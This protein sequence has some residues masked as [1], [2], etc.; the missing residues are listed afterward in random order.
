[1]ANQASD[2]YDAGGAA[3]SQVFNYTKMTRFINRI[4]LEKLTLKTALRATA[5]LDE[6]R[7]NAKVRNGQR[8]ELPVRRRLSGTTKMVSIYDDTSDF[9]GDSPYATVTPPTGGGIN[10][11]RTTYSE[12]DSVRNMEVQWAFMHDNIRFSRVHL[13]WAASEGKF[14]DYFAENMD[15]IAD[16]LKVFAAQQ[17]N[18]G[19]GRG[20]AAANIGNSAEMYG[21]YNQVT[22]WSGNRAANSGRG[23]DNDPNN[24]HFGILRHQFPNMVGN[25]WRADIVFDPASTGAEIRYLDAAGVV[26][27]GPVTDLDFTGVTY[28]NCHT[29]IDLG[30]G[31]LPTAY[32][33][34]ELYV[35]VMPTT[36]SLAGQSFKRIV[37]CGGAGADGFQI[38]QIIEDPTLDDGDPITVNV[39]IRPKYEFATEGEAG[40]WTVNKIHKA[41]THDGVMDGQDVINMISV[42]ASRFYSFMVQLQQ[43]QRWYGEDPYL[44]SE[45]YQNFM[46]NAA[47][48]TVDNYERETDVRMSNTKHCQLY[49]LKGYDKFQLTEDGLYKDTSGRRVDSLVGDVLWGGQLVGR[50]P[51][52]DARV[53]GIGSRPVFR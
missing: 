8:F 52:R 22:S 6:L 42:N 10:Q 31:T 20:N 14:M 5:H 29:D 15:Y 40:V 23:I 49:M 41:Y 27:T 44:L 45:G 4:L 18:F 38:S 53:T 13:Q 1:M 33:C 12:K 7:K 17:I 46:F 34:D 51:N 19:N 3:S 48:V 43:L 25:I 9:V 2:F 16:S 26:Q 47:R 50:S 21:I 36:G 39:A 30:A 28:L 37:A 24:V 35:Y 11:V 32:D